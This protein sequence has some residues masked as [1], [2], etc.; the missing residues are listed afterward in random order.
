MCSCFFFSLP[1]VFNFV[2][3]RISHF[4]TAAAKFSFLSSNEIG[5]F[6]VVSLCHSL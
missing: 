3:A 1:L 4:L 2:A 5:H 6:T